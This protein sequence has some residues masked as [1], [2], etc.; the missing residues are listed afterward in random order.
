MILT[1]KSVDLSEADSPPSYELFSSS[2]L[3]VLTGQGWPHSLKKK[4][5]PEDCL[6][7][8]TSPLLLGRSWVCQPILQTLDLSSWPLELCGNPKSNPPASS[9]VADLVQTL[10]TLSLWNHEEIKGKNGKLMA[11]ACWPPLL[12][13]SSMPCPSFVLA[14]QA[15]QVDSRCRQSHASCSKN[16]P[17]LLCEDEDDLPE[18]K[19][20][21]VVYHQS[22]WQLWDNK[23]IIRFYWVW[24]R[25]REGCHTDSW[26]S[27]PSCWHFCLRLACRGTRLQMKH[28]WEYCVGLMFHL[29][30]GNSIS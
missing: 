6:Q 28:L 8:W 15:V 26:A 29:R 24:G 11:N 22:L 23:N 9:S 1:F 17:S 12:L 16:S 25:T 14:S 10:T 18:Q 19:N 5:L 30:L 21:F 4:N 13:S 20:D 3:K 27:A 2:K 7:A